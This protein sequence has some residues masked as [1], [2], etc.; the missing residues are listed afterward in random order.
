MPCRQDA[1]SG[2]RLNQESPQHVNS[3]QTDMYVLPKQ[4]KPFLR[5]MLRHSNYEQVYAKHLGITELQ[6]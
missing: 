4:M 2:A 6:R 1:D 3:A 5:I